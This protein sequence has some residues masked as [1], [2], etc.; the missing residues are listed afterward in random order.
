[1]KKKSEFRNILPVEIPTGERSFPIIF[2]TELTQNDVEAPSGTR[3]K[4]KNKGEQNKKR[5]T[6]LLLSHQNFAGDAATATDA[7]CHRRA[8]T[9]R[10]VGVHRP[11]AGS[12]RHVVSDE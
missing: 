6:H 8:A 1:M 2:T 12:G 4:Q 5:N 7:N 3:G 11:L 9:G 10:A